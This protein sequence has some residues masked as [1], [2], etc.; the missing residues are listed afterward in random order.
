MVVVVVVVT[1]WQVRPLQSG[2]EVLP[3]QSPL[4]QS[5]VSPLSDGSTMPLPHVGVLVAPLSTQAPLRHC[6]PVPQI[7]PSGSSTSVPKN[8]QKP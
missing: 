6:L 5:Q 4:P 8:Q 3:K 7:M 2:S 1:A